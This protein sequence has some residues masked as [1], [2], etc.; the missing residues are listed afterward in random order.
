MKANFDGTVE[1]DVTVTIEGWYL[2]YLLRQDQMKASVRI[3]DTETNTDTSIDLDAPVFDAPAAEKWCTAPY[4]Y[5]EINEFEVVSAVT[6]YSST[7]IA[8]RMVV[9][10]P[11]GGTHTVTID[12]N[13]DFSYVNSNTNA[14]L[15]LFGAFY[16]PG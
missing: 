2:K 15:V 7:V 13:G 9:M 14:T 6:I 12:S 4:Y 11:N 5:G 1:K 8:G 3:H 16:D 10:G